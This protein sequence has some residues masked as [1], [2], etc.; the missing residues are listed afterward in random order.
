MNAA[1]RVTY[2]LHSYVPTI[3]MIAVNHSLNLVRHTTIHTGV[4]GV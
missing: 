2:A 4:A 3:N 1:H